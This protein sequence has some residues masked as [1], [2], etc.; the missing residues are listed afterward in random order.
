MM[1]ATPTATGL[2]LA[3]MDLTVTLRGATVAEIDSDATFG[4]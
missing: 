4:P 1:A 2:D 3:S